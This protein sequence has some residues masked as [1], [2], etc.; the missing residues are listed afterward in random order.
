MIRRGNRKVA[1]MVLG[2]ASGPELLAHIRPEGYDILTIYEYRNI[3]DI[4]SATQH[5]TASTDTTSAC[6]A[7]GAASK[8]GSPH[9]NGAAP[10]NGRPEGTGTDGRD[11]VTDSDGA[12]GAGSFIIYTH[13]ELAAMK[14]A[15]THYPYRLLAAWS[16]GVWA[17][18]RLFGDTLFDKA[19]ALNG[20]PIPAD[21]TTG[22]GARRLGVTLRGIEK[23]GLA[24][25]NRKAYGPYADLAGTAQSARTP[26]DHT[27][28]LATLTAL[29]SEPYRPS[30]CWTTAIVG[31]ED[32]IFPPENMFRYWGKRAIAVTSPHYP[33][34]DENI[35][36]I[37]F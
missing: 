14:E 6:G 32:G 2:W 23:S 24:P 4:V 31:I 10:E 9:K 30:V 18:E 34:G 25:F 8:E 16:F 37:L 36:K 26:A 5:D 20:T 33:F 21:E 19:V 12:Y 27:A 13:S 3:G 35:L 28:E 29:S 22:I 15:I 11:P 7:E 1:V 17:A